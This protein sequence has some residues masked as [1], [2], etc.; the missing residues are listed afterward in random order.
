MCTV[1]T[2]NVIIYFVSHQKM[3]CIVNTHTHSSSYYS[4]KKIMSA[5][6]TQFLHEEGWWLTMFYFIDKKFIYFRFRPK[7][8]LINRQKI[9]K[10][11]Q[12][13]SP[14]FSV[15]P[16]SL[17]FKQSRFQH[18]VIII[19]VSKNNILIVVQSMAYHTIFF[20]A[21]KIENI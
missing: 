3:I 6:L 19:I 2:N 7:I 20:T 16:P 21:K 8:E 4:L 10:T 1:G 17:F 15:M 11:H 5:Y 12:M 18:H 14:K 9:V 13:I